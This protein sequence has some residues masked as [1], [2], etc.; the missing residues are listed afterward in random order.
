MKVPGIFDLERFASFVEFIRTGPGIRSCISSLPRKFLRY[1]PVR[2]SQTE[3][4]S[5]YAR[6]AW[7]RLRDIHELA[8]YSVI[9]GYIKFIRPNGT[10]LDVGCGEGLLLDVTASDTYS[11]YVGIDISE[12][13]VQSALKKKKQRAQFIRAEAELYNAEQLFDVIVFNE[14]LYYFDDPLRVVKRYERFL[15][16]NGVF[17]VSMYERGKTRHVWKMLEMEYEVYDE[18]HISSGTQVFWDVKV[19]TPLGTTDPLE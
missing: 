3:W 5:M 19:L 10:I 15:N 9:G 18:V 2:V 17:I 16:K 14:S 7:D 13:A 11:F 4:D 6:G 12:Q 1:S 8:H